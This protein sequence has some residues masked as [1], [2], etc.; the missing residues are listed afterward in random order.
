MSSPFQSLRSSAVE[1]GFDPILAW[2]W[3]ICI[4]AL[5]ISG[6][7][8]VL[9]NS[10]QRD[11]TRFGW[12]VLSAFTL[13]S[14]LFNVIVSPETWMSRAAHA[15]PP[16]TLMVSVEILLSIIRS[17]LSPKG[18]TPVT[19][20]DVTSERGDI[21]PPVT[22]IHQGTGKG[23]TTDQVLQFFRENPSASYVTAAA[24]LKIARQTVSR[25]VS[26]LLEDGRLEREGDQFV[27][28]DRDGREYA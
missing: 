12:L 6:S 3:P 1:A 26:R 27:I 21:T 10:L 25:H 18:N 24:N 11:S 28:P 4:D 17:D 16:I 2:C 19:Y 15:I 8:M 9:R 13:V 5:L 20:Q 14:I 7:L 23:V 22:L